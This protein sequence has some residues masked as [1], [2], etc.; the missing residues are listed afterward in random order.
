[1]KFRLSIAFIL[2]TQLGVAQSNLTYKNFTHDGYKLDVPTNWRIDTSKTLGANFFAFSPADDNTLD[3]FS[4]NV[5]VMIQ[6]LQGQDIS[7][8]Q[9]KEISENQFN[10]LS[11][12]FSDVET[13]IYKKGTSEF[14]IFKYKMKQ[15]NLALN[16]FSKCMIRNGSAYLATFAYEETAS[17]KYKDISDRI[18]LSFELD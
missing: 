9:Y 3:K 14:L 10:S 1:M 12:K 17:D 7:L 13:V 4:E 11:D 16:V 15:G 8:Q 18:I 6:N 5:N 2:L